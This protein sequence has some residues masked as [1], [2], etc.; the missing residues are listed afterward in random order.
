MRNSVSWGAIVT[1]ASETAL[2]RAQDR[3]RANTILESLSQ[4]AGDV[5]ESYR[6]LYGIGRSS[7]AAIPE[8]RPLFRIPGIE[9]DGALAITDEF[10]KTVRALAKEILPQISNPTAR[11]R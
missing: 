7:N 9:A 4:G 6:A 2:R 8:L 3:R 1:P 10:K 5:Y 11:T